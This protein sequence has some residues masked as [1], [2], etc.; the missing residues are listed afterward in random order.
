MKKALSGHRHP[1]SEEGIL[2][3]GAGK[4]IE[5][6][7]SRDTEPF[8]QLDRAA[9]AKVEDVVM[10][11]DERMLYQLDPIQG[12]LV[13]DDEV[14]FYPQ[15]VAEYLVSV[16]LWY[17]SPWAVVENI[18][19]VTFLVEDPVTDDEGCVLFIYQIVTRAKPGLDQVVD[20]QRQAGIVIHQSP[21]IE[22][23]YGLVQIEVGR[24]S[25]II[26]GE[27][28]LLTTVDPAA[29][30]I[31]G[32][33]FFHGAECDGIAEEVGMNGVGI[34]DVARATV[35]IMKTDCIGE[36]GRVP[37]VP[38]RILFESINMAEQGV[39]V[40]AVLYG[41]W[42]IDLTCRQHGNKKYYN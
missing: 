22:V 26:V 6:K 31:E 38:Y 29:A 13:A 24:G 19:Q 16:S 4:F 8:A 3:A 33:T 15:R 40:Q 18:L 12:D 23:A 30:R 20:L 21:I 41:L 28:T 9:G 11:R 2:A 17:I 1:K 35:G 14:I 34:I 10:D 37:G 7:G 32:A 5:G 42:S 25:K 39:L 27:V 36:M